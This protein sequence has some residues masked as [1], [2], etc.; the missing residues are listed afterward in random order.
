MQWISGT[1]RGAEGSLCVEAQSTDGARTLARLV[2]LKPD[3][4]LPAVVRRKVTLPLHDM[5]A[6]S[7]AD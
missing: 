1:S 6:S 2:D 3:L 5:R 7:T 4:A